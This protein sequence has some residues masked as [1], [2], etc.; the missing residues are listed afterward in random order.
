MGK[1]KIFSISNNPVYFA[2]SNIDGNILLEF[3]EVKKAQGISIA[4]SGQAYVHWTE[5]R[6]TGDGNERRTETYHYSDS[7]IIFNDVLIQLW[8]NSRDSQEITSGRYEFAFKFQLP[9]NLM[10]PTSF[11]SNTGFIHYSL[12]ATIKR[13]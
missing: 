2:G 10:L 4:L 5:Q 8:G 9:S 6:T 3:S 12:T 7:Q 13:S 1:P 11:E